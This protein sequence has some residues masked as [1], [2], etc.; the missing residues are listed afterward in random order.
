MKTKNLL[1]TGRMSR[2][3]KAKGDAAG[4]SRDRL[5]LRR[6][7]GAGSVRKRGSK[8]RSLAHTPP[9]RVVPQPYPMP[10]E[11]VVQAIEPENAEEGAIEIDGKAFV[12]PILRLL[13]EC[14]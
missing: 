9:R 4:C 7:R 14:G 5:R 13:A 6:I 10:F 11:E 12:P 2:P 3:S 8:G 1:P